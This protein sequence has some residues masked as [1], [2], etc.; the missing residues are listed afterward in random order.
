MYNYM[1]YKYLFENTANKNLE[2][3]DIFNNACIN[4]FLYI[5]CYNI[6]DSTTYP[7]LQFMMEKIPF[8]NNFIKE[9]FTLPFV[10]FDNSTNIQEMVV[11]KVKY[12]LTSVG[13]D[14]SNITDEI[15][16]GVYIDDGNYS[17]PYA[18]VNIT[19]IDISGINFTRQT[20]TWFSLPSEIINTKSI[21][22]ID[23][24]QE[25]TDLFTN[26]PY[27]GLLTNPITSKTYI[28]PDAVYTGNEMKQVEFNSIFGNIKTKEYNNCSNYFYFY[29]SFK[30]AVKQG[31]WI[32]IDNYKNLDI[33]NIEY[34]KL[35]HN[36]SGKKI[37]E[38][39]YG[40]YINGGINR[41]ALFIEGKLHI[42]QGTEFSLDDDLIERL[43][44]EPT[45]TISY[46][47]IHN[48]N[49]R[50]DILVK[51]YDSFASL[52]YHVLNKRLLDDKYVETNN[53]KYMIL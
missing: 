41:F 9:Q 22:N 35:T 50:P 23:I 3:P 36:S 42:E 38:N 46:S 13:C 52:S 18:L 17:K 4:N 51:K 20:T 29:K 16:N 6:T 31:G 19:G 1:N 14:V 27:L 12:S 8:C 40:R 33:N 30:D 7:F 47:D 26:I 39:E 28:L 43:Y 37:V 2:A 21:C 10:L 11:N 15:Y 24:D 34:N 25:V 44:P 5:L 45:I 53:S 49:T 48:C 32:N